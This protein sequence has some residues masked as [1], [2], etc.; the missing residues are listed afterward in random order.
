M[1]QDG[2]TLFA[3]EGDRIAQIGVHLDAEELR[4]L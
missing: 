1:R 4:G 3:S 2:A